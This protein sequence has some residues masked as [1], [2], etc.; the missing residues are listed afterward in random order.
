MASR[1]PNGCETSEIRALNTS[2][3]RLSSA[4]SGEID[5]NPTKARLE[6]AEA[7]FIDLLHLSLASEAKSLAIPKKVSLPI[8]CQGLKTISFAYRLRAAGPLVTLFKR[9]KNL[10]AIGD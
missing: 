5:G 9:R 2:R 6:Q 4:I 3:P 8:L 7:T 10:K 1:G